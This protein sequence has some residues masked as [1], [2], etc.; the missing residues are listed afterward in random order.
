[1]FCTFCEIMAS[2]SGLTFDKMIMM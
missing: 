1:M 2:S